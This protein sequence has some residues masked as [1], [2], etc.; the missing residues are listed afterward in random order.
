MRVLHVAALPFPSP[1]GTQAL[2]HQMLCAHASA[3]HDAHLLCYPH[4][5]PSTAPYTVHRCAGGGL[6]A[7]FRSGPSWSKLALD[8]ALALS[9]RRLVRE[10]RPALVVAHHV[11]AALLALVCRV[12]ALFYAH[13]D[14]GAEL[15]CYF[16]PRYALPL[17][18][19]GTGLDRLLARR[20]RTLAVSPLLA[21]KLDALVP[22]LPWP[23]AVP[24]RRDQHA[25]PTALY[26]GN[27]DRYQGLDALIAAVAARPKLRWLVATA[28]PLREF[29]RAATAILPRVRFVPLAGERARQRAYAACD[30]V[31]VPRAV[32]GGV[33]IKLF[34]A[35]ARGV[36]TIAARAA[37]AGYPLEPYCSVVDDDWPSAIDGVLADLAGAQE[38]AS[39]ALGY[40]SAAHPPVRF[41]EQL[42]D[43]LNPPD[44]ARA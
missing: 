20:M 11:E 30:F 8:G 28:S 31:L 36:P 38:R 41:A 37:L 33:P 39:R 18:L 3:G 9:L 21:A 24:V 27:L 40:L 34:D 23:A 26:A 17:R 7:S 22:T 35:L 10:L 16:A 32:P 2:L 12:P 42:S 44:A 1:Q 6:P 25:H 15:P 19:A 43:L 14:L 5:A 4:G 13:T 29:A